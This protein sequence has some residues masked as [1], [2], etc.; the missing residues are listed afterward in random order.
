MQPNRHTP[1]VVDM[2]ALYAEVCR[3]AVVRTTSPSALAL[4]AGIDPAVISRLKHGHLSDLGATSLLNLA[5]VL[6]IDPRLLLVS[7]VT[8]KPLTPS[9]AEATA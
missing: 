2:D 7:R 1:Y 5:V 6:D 4:D 9:T 3:Q 8:G